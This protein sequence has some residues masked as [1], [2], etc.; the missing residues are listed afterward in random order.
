MFPYL[1]DGEAERC[2]LRTPM[3]FVDLT[4]GDNVVRGALSKDVIFSRLGTYATTVFNDM[5]L[6]L[7]MGL[8]FSPLTFPLNGVARLLLTELFPLLA[9]SANA[10]FSF[11]TYGAYAPFHTKSLSYLELLSDS[12]K[13]SLSTFRGHATFM[14]QQAV[15]CGLGTLGVNELIQ[16]HAIAFK[17]VWVASANPEKGSDWLTTLETA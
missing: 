7:A 10:G 11:S 17:P 3:I 13:L 2:V 1:S 16:K 4:W 9:Q 5:G 8:H 6:A 15:I 12:D 14:S